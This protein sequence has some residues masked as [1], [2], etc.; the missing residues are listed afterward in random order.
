VLAEN[1]DSY[2]QTVAQKPPAERGKS[3]KA[4]VI[5][6]TFSPDSKPRADHSENCKRAIEGHP[7]TT[8]LPVVIDPFPI[9]LCRG[10]NVAPLASSN[11]NLNSA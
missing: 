8:N 4:L 7:G 1:V 11:L 3:G 5:T 2:N 6:G 9:P 10:A